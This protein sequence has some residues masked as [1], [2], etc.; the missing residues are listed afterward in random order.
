MVLSVG[1]IVLFALKISTQ[2]RLLGRIMGYQP[3]NRPRTNGHLRFMARFRA[4]YESKSLVACP[5]R[6][7]GMVRNYTIVPLGTGKW[8]ATFLILFGI[9]VA[10]IAAVELLHFGTKCSLAQVCTN[11]PTSFFG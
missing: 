10:V 2:C 5:V 9:E 3:T 1:L 4:S 11:F 8:C 6:I 7:V